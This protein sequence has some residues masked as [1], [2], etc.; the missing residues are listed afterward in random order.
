MTLANLISILA[1]LAFVGAFVYFLITDADFRQFF[2]VGL[3]S[4]IV[5]AGSTLLACVIGI[6]M[7]KGL[8][9]ASTVQLFGGA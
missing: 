5:M 3:V 8:D 4:I 2:V 1:G 7:L 9:W 6:L